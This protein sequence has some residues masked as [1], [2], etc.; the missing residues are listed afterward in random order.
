MSDEATVTSAEIARLANVGRAA[1]SN[2]RK[3]HPDFPEPVGGTSTFRR[4][5]VEQWLRKQGKLADATAA[6]AVWRVLDAQPNALDLV[7]DLAAYV[8]DQPGTKPSAEVRDLLDGLPASERADLVEALCSRVFERQQRQH[9][10]TPT[11]LSHLMVELAAPLAGVVFDPACGSGNLLHAADQ[12]ETLVG[13]ELDQTLARLARARLNTEIAVGD[14]LRADAFPDLRA[15][16]VLCDPPFGYRDWGHEELGVDP[17]WEYGFPVK[18]EAELAW[19]QHCLAHTKPG[20]TVVIVLPASVSSRRSGRLIRQA[21]LRRGAIRAVVALPAGALMS[22][23]IALHLWVLRN[24]AEQG[25]DPVLLVDASHHQP[26]RRGQVDWASLEAEVLHPWREFRETGSVTDIP[27][28]C[29][30]VE[31]IE[32]LDEDVDLT[33]ALH[34]PPVPVELDLTAVAAA[35]SRVTRLLGELGELLPAV[36]Q[37]PRATR[38]MTTIHDLS[39]AGALALFQQAGPVNT[40]EGGAGPRVLTG[41]DVVAGESPTGR[42]SASEH[43]IPLQRG[44][45]VVPMLAAGDAVVRPVVIEEDDLALGPNLQLLRVDETR[46]DPYFLAGQLR[47]AKPRTFSSTL[48][49]VHRTDVR[50]IE[51][52]VLDLERQRVLGEAFR[53]IAAFQTGVELAAGLG[54]ELAAQLIEGLAD[55]AVEPGD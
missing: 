7:A 40:R 30:A 18:G 26:P 11:G 37:A 33:P 48:S 44:D 55:G 38:V 34:L 25:V 4:D 8:A 35:Q 22:T 31:A 36:R 28:R 24:P 15:D 29:R 19:V 39:R 52:P 12:A 16:T 14:A 32:L 21:L 47:G 20:G 3:R 13:Q 10:M 9:L 54:T 53:R 51:V 27:G 50:R 17:R 23:G 2:W 6:D 42:V 41:R 1:V 45:V 46:M 49:G 5:E 43:V